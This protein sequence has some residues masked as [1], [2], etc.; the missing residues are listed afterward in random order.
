MFSQKRK[1]SERN[2]GVSY[3]KRKKEKDER[4]PF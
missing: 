2:N 3:Q 1:M 4:S